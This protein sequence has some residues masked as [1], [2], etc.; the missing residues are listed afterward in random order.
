MR[1]RRA[2]KPAGAHVASRTTIVG[3]SIL[4]TDRCRR[5]RSASAATS[6][7]T[8]W[9]QACTPAS[10][11]P[12][13]VSSTGW[14]RTRSRAAAEGAGYRG[15]APEGRSRERR[16]E[17]GDEQAEPPAL[18]VAA[19]VLGPSSAG[20]LLAA[21]GVPGWARRARCGP[22]GRCHPALARA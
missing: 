9:P 16:T 10:V 18:G 6:R 5:A 2:S 12:A 13:Q 3:A 8:T 4:L 19:A 20:R 11:R 22:W 17:V 7:V 1:E 21:T 15:A 14:R